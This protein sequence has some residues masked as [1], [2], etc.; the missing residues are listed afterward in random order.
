MKT[1]KDY[2]FREIVGENV[3]VPSGQAAQKINGMI[4]LSETASF[5]WGLYDKKKNLDEIVG[6]VLDEFEIDTETARRDVF[7]FS[8]LLYKEGIIMEVPEFENGKA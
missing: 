4:H 8:E 6:A 2:I 5:I 1:N 3:L 7:G